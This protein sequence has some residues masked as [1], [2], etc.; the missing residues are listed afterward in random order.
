MSDSELLRRLAELVGQS[1]R[2]EAD[3]VA[4]IAE[5]DERRLYARK[6]APSMFAYGTDALHLSE[7]EAY[8]RISVARASREYPQLLDM[9][10]D[11]RLHLS[12]IAVLAP[13]LTAGNAQSLLARATH[14]TKRRIEELVADL[15]PRPDVAASIRRLPMPAIGEI[16]RESVPR[17]AAALGQ[18]SPGVVQQLA[19]PGNGEPCLLPPA[20]GAVDSRPGTKPAHTERTVVEPLGDARYKVQ[21]TAGAELRRKLERLQAL[22][23]GVDLAAAVDVAVTEMLERIESKRFGKMR[24]PKA[25]ARH[26]NGEPPAGARYIPAAVRRA[27]FERDGHRCRFVDGDG[28]RC[29]ERDRLEFHH[30]HPFGHG[31]GHD[32]GNIRLMCR[33]HNMLL[34]EADYGGKTLA[35][36]R[37]SRASKPWREHAPLPRN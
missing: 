33:T 13:H 32:I 20:T 17:M 21:F 8:L 30:R 31:G 9:L 34:A 37:V 26:A 11:G 3:L 16:S 23:P 22:M 18:E 12:S 1:R 25:R 7:S 24:A 36:H 5:V 10:A 28:T 15:A 14:K 27:V 6:A 19:P 2:V 35:K 29:R 4:L